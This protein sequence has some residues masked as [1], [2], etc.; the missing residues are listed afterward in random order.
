[1]SIGD[2]SHTRMKFVTFVK[3][4]VWC[5]KVRRGPCHTVCGLFLC[6][7]SV[8]GYYRKKDA[9]VVSA[10]RFECGFQFWPDWAAVCYGWTVV[11]HCRINL[12]LSDIPDIFRAM[13]DKLG[14]IRH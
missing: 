14:F 13:S 8:L 2:I 9:I 7:Q 3:V 5:C 4:E 1:M 12:V 10:M 11:S 6:S